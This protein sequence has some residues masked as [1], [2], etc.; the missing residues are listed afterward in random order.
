VDG[1]TIGVADTFREAVIAL[2]ITVTDRICVRSEVDDSSYSAI[3]NF[4]PGDL[5][6]ILANLVAN[7]VDAISHVGE[8]N[9]RLEDHANEVV[10]SVSDSG[11]GMA[12]DVV[13][14]A[15]ERGFTFD[16]VGGSGLGLFHAKSK[17]EAW[18]GRLA[19]DSQPG[20]GTVVSIHL[21]LIDRE[22][23]YV[24]R[25]K[26]SNLD[27]AV[28]VDDQ[29]TARNLWAMTLKESGFIG[30]VQFAASAAEAAHLLACDDGNGPGRLHVFA[31]YDLGESAPDGLAVLREAS[32]KAIRYLVTG[33]FDEIAVRAA[34]RRDGVSLLAKTALSRVP[35]VVR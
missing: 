27:R 30:R 13:A 9:L 28:V 16:K 34:C 23:W 6:D 12:T 4:R 32:G 25:I 29:P 35:V 8:I 11:R 20:K 22:P 31:D 1:A 10:L 17:V 7:A 5:K 18:G 33:H 3:V 26:L 15:G 14:R 19:I 21:P 24:P 2:S